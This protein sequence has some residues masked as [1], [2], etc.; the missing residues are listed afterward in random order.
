ME[1]WLCFC[2]Q[3]YKTCNVQINSVE[4]IEFSRD[5]L[6]PPP[7]NHVATESCASPFSMVVDVKKFLSMEKNFFCGGDEALNYPRIS[8]LNLNSNSGTKKKYRLRHV[9]RPGTPSAMV[10]SIACLVIAW[11]CQVSGGAAPLSTA[12]HTH[13]TQDGQGVPDAKV[14]ASIP[15]LADLPMD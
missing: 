14:L 4:G 12:D 11:W 7:T 1:H 9:Q 2:R 13:I 3:Q 15:S 10:I 6:L 8:S 5:H